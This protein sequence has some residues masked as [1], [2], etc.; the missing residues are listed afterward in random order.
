MSSRGS[1]K[2]D[3]TR[4]RAFNH[5]EHALTSLHA[6]ITRSDLEE[7]FIEAKFPWSWRSPGETFTVRISG[8]DGAV[9]LEVSSRL[10]TIWYGF[11]DFGKNA[12]N[13]RRF[14]TSPAFASS[15]IESQY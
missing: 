3:L 1:V 7:G 12:E 6:R 13:V 10:R 11:M 14:V 15:V 2:V 8:V 5:A 9:L 4:T